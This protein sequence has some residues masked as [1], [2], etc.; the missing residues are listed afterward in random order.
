MYSNAHHIYRDYFKCFTLLHAS[1]K[2]TC[3]ILRTIKYAFL[4]PTAKKE[5]FGVKLPGCKI[6]KLYTSIKLYIGIPSGLSVNSVT[7]SDQLYQIWMHSWI[8]NKRIKYTLSAKM[9]QLINSRTRVISMNLNA[10]EKQA[11]RG[12]TIIINQLIYKKLN[13]VRKIIIK[14]TFYLTVNADI[15]FHFSC[16]HFAYKNINFF[17]CLYVFSH[18]SIRNIYQNHFLD[19]DDKF[20]LLFLK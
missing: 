11:C 3:T 1:I 18:D 8:C 12:L 9:L 20:L 7:L 16:I 5:K 4:S 2:H 13:G 10:L 17:R 19:R 14:V 15:P 6:L